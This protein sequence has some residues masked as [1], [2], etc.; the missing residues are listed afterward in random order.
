MTAK[1][2][3]INQAP[4]PAVPEVTS[5]YRSR[6]W[7]RFSRH[8]L[9]VVSL[10]LIVVLALASAAASWLAPYDP[11]KVNARALYAPPSAEHW[12]GTDEVGRDVLSRL[13]YAGRVSLSVGAVASTLAVALGTLIGMTSGYFGGAIDFWLMRFTEVIMTIPTLII[14]ITLIASIGP[15]IYN[16]MVVIGLVGWTE[17]ARLVRAETLSLRS[18]DFVIAS[19]ALG[20]GNA[21][22]IFRHILPNVLAP[23][24][25]AA[26]FFVAYAIL[27]EAALSFLG[28]GVRIPTATWGNMLNQALKLNVLENMPWLWLPPG[29]LIS[30]TVLGVNF[31]GDALRDALDPRLQIGP[32]S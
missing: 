24:T 5:S 13:L 27:L 2:A 9:G 3:V 20:A 14:I 10:A 6:F 18:R 11:F 28:I 22:I 8:R 31:V 7:Q 30:L 17:M 23:V 12:L 19:Q 32:N 16:V 1:V 25:V 4:S 26:T 15:N 29:L 21:H